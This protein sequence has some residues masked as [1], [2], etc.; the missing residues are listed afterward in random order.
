MANSRRVALLACGLGLLA[1]CGM[2]A[3]IDGLEIGQCKG[4]LCAP[5]T[6]G[7]DARPEEGGTDTGPPDDAGPL[8][9]CTVGTKGPKMVR[10]GTSANNFCIDSTEVTLG[11]YREFTDA[12]GTD[13]GGQLPV[14]AWNVSY[15]AGAGG[16]DDNLPV[17]GVDWCDAVA[18]CK[19][20]GKRLCG[21]HEGGSFKGAVSLTGLAD[22]NT[23]EWLLACSNVGQLR[24]PYGGIQQPTACNTGENDAGRTLPVASKPACAGGFAGVNDM[25]GNVWEWFD[26]PCVPPDAGGD[27]AAADSGPQKEECIVKGGS[28]AITGSNLGCASDGRGAA[29]DRRA[30]D[31][32]IRCCSD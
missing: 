15:A 17:A 27:A 4:G 8:G 14:C 1:A 11:H 18:Y 6:G 29:R 16:P 5:E 28:Y 19:F 9:P 32:G 23:H 22:F 10:V 30:L 7:T 24:Y 31:V 12:K 26:G 13:A 2:V 25:I 20:A 21:K 3:G